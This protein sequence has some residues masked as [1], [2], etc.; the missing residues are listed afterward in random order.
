VGLA[1]LDIDGVVAD[2]RHR[3]HH[4]ERKP[5]DWM[6]F[7]RAADAD[8]PIPEGLE[9]A[10][11]MARDHELV[12][13][14]GRPEWSAPMTARWLAEQ[15]LP[16]TEMH[17]RPHRDYRPARLFKLGVLRR[18]AS[19]QIVAFVDDDAEVVEAAR[20]AGFPA[21]LADWMPRQPV[22]RDAQ[23]RLGRT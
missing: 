11:R 17:L 7:F 3:L 2:V 22:L 23:D 20:A 18:L 1:I 6:A 16:T 4:L 15:G 8:Q 9:L 14:S 12:W 21:M 10:A 5:K 19:R 13:L